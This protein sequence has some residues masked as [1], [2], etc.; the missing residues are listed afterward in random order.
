MSRRTTIVIGLGATG[1][2][3]VRHLAASDRVLAID[4]RAAPPFLQA[5]QREL[6]QVEILAPRH[7]HGALRAAERVVVSPGI[8]LDHCLVATA[9]A[10]GA[11]ITSDIELFLAAAAAP[12]VGITG[13]NGK[14][15]VATLV[16]ELLAAAG[17]DVG[18]GGNLGTPALDLLAEDRDGYVLELSSFQLERLRRPGL[19]VAAV[20]NVS[21]D[22]LDRYPSLDAYAA[23]K[24]RIYAG[25]GRAVFNALDPRTAPDASMSD[26]IALHRDPRWR[27]DGDD[28][29]A[30]GARLPTAALAMQ[31]RH[32]HGNALAALAIAHQ[33]G[34]GVA[35]AKPVLSRFQGLPHRATVVAEVGGVTFVNDSKAT[36]VGACLAALAGFGNGAGNI[37]L[38][39]GGDAKGASFDALGSAVARHVGQLVLLGRDADVIAQALAGAAPT[40]RARDMGDAVRIAH[41]VA[42]PGDVVLLSPA[43]AS[44][45]MYADYRARGD[46]FTA[47]VQEFAAAGEPTL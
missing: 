47:M 10:A 17:A 38:I 13:T 30:D 1:Y 26:A 23:S 29:V 9:R 16:G 11:A 39:A 43:C 4:T 31:G 7:W 8:A 12:V 20:L 34:V 15:T 24:R 33:A 5:V 28:L 6:P 44:F 45:D 2:S 19:A 46:H 18:V 32:N 37:V 27:L 40:A 3:C 22:H 41:N 14:S 35:A 36:N 25:A 21:A 42:R